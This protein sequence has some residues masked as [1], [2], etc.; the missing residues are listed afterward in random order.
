MH[1]FTVEIESE[2]LFTPPKVGIL[3]DVGTPHW[4]KLVVAGLVEALEL[5]RASYGKA[6]VES[7]L[8][9]YKMK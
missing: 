5:M 4:E 3:G 9:A 8:K 6:L 1:K 7:T 2:S